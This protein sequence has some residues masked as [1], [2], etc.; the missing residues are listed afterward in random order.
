MPEQVAA[1]QFYAKWCALIEADAAVWRTFWLRSL[2]GQ[3]SRS[4]KGDIRGS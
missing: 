3:V 4:T 2:L 1:R